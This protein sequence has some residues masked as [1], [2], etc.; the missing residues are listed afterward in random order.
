MAATSTVNTRQAAGL[1]NLLTPRTNLD[2][3]TNFFSV[4]VVGEQN[5]IPSEINM[6]KNLYMA[7]RRN[8][9]GQ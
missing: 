8:C 5:V 7:P 1:L 6:A 4:G 2:L 9:E 3:R